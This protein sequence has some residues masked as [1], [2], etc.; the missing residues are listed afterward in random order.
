MAAKNAKSR[1]CR[2]GRYG[3]DTRRLHDRGEGRSERPLDLFGTRFCAA[4]AAG[5]L[6]A[7]SKGRLLRATSKRAKVA[8]TLRVRRLPAHGVCGL[9]SNGHTTQIQLLLTGFSHSATYGRLFPVPNGASKRPEVDN[10]T[11]RA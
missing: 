7:T 5:G 4:P 2:A 11:H 6:S 3:R 9:L 1:G 10:Q 8:R